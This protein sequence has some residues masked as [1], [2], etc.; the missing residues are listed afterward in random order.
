M[1]D[2]TAC[3]RWT[4]GIPD[5]EFYQRRP[6]KGLITKME[7]RIISLARLNLKEQSVLWDI[8][9]GSGSMSIEAAAMARRRKVFA[10]EKDPLDIQNIKK[11]IEKFGV[12]NVEVIDAFAPEGLNPLPAPDAVF[13]GGSGGK[14][15]GIIENVC[16]RIKPSGRLVMNAASIENLAT[17]LEVLK[18]LGWETE[19]TMV[20]IARGKTT[21]RVTR[22]ESLNPVF[23]LSAWKSSLKTDEASGS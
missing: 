14:L 4:P 19:A 11:N 22:F 12:G 16:Q 10:I 2:R 15:K 17:A 13:I 6:K 23:I 9:A 18:A 5:S 21:G 7:V 3:K 1:G 20:N 8:G